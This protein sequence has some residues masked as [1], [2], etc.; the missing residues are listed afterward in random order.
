MPEYGDTVQTRIAT[1]D[2]LHGGGV[3]DGNW[4]WF[5]DGAN[6]DGNPLGVL[7]EPPE[8]PRKRWQNIVKYHQTILNGLV[9]DFDEFKKGL[10]QSGNVYPEADA[11]L[12]ELRRKQQAVKDRQAALAEAQAELKTHLPGYLPPDEEEAY[13]RAK[14]ARQ[15]DEQR[16]QDAVDAVTI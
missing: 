5:E 3:F 1:F 10:K 9:R 14:A 11:P 16:Y 2:R 13:L 7:L 8:D 6:R 15:A 12:A 4:I